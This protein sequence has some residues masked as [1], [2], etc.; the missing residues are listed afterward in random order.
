M[1]SRTVEQKTEFIVYGQPT[2]RS[3]S[4]EQK[5]TVALRLTEFLYFSGLVNKAFPQWQKGISWFVN[6]TH[7]D[8]DI[9]N[10]LHISIQVIH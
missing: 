3:I 8:S 4:G 6:Q 7:G 5:Y 1:H 10:Q 9:K 2:S